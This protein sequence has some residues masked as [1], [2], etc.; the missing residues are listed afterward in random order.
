MADRSD[1]SGCE[2]RFE[3]MPGPG[4]HNSSCG[5]SVQGQ[6]TRITCCGDHRIPVSQPLNHPSA[7]DGRAQRHPLPEEPLLHSATVTLTIVPHSCRTL[8]SVWLEFISCS[9]PSA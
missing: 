8:D 3:A 7:L 2:Y 1:Q 9:R 4:L 5:C 6:F